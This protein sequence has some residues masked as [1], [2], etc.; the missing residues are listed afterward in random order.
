VIDTPQSPTPDPERHDATAPGA[1]ATLATRP[2][3]QEAKREVIEFVKMV[4]WFL[5]LFFGLRWAVIEGY[6]VQGPSMEPALRSEERILVLKLPY[7]LSKLWPFHGIE[8]I[9]EGDIVVFD[10][11]RSDGRRFVKRVIAKGPAAPNPKTVGAE[12]RGEDSRVMVEYERGRVYVDHRLLD[13]VYLAHDTLQVDDSVRE[14][15]GP[16]EYYVL[17]DNRIVSMDSRSFGPINGDRIIGRAFLRFW[18]LHKISL[19]K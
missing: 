8:A 1:A 13:E 11:P 16:G 10:S 3:A 4:L 12:Q 2:T 9:G 19:L 5:V 6:E 15:V 18:P 7:K 17:G 14:S